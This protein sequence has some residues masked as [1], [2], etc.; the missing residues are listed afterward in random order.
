MF[1]DERMNRAG[2]IGYFKN[3]SNSAGFIV[4][5]DGTSAFIPKGISATAHGN[6]NN[7]SLRQEQGSGENRKAFTDTF[8]SS[9]SFRTLYKQHIENL[10][11]ENRLT[12]KGHSSTDCENLEVPEE[13]VRVYDSPAELMTVIEMQVGMDRLFKREQQDWIN[14]FI[15]DYEKGLYGDQFVKEDGT[16]G[17]LK[18]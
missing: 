13:L 9:E 11:N 6:F 17:C 8:R 18:S 1:Y 16:F 7:V 3:R 5:D 2:V 10:R 14:Q 12:L 15:L 4:F